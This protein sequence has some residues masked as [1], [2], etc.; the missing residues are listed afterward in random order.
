MK[1]SSCVYTRA[2]RQVTRI[3]H[4]SLKNRGRLPMLCCE[5][6]EVSSWKVLIAMLRCLRLIRVPVAVWARVGHT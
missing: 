1:P 2:A 4:V 6:V 5:Q 3:I